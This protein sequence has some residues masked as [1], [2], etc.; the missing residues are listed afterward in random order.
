MFVGCFVLVLEPSK[1]TF[2]FCLCVSQKKL[3]QSLIF[4]FSN[5][6]AQSQVI[7]RKK[8]GE[9]KIRFQDENTI[10]KMKTQKYLTK[11]LQLEKNEC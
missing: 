2:P 9:K 3:N 4:I 1:S 7:L 6:K 8:K 10:S 5:C 11:A